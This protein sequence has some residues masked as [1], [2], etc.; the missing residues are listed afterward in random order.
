MSKGFSRESLDLSQEKWSD[1]EQY[2]ACLGR[3]LER[4]KKEIALAGPFINSKTAWKCGILGQVLLYRVTMLAIGC[5]DAWKS[6]NVV[7]SVLAARALLE[8]IAVC[9]FIKERLQSSSETKNVDEI[10]ELANAQLFSTRN[11]EIVSEGFGFQA[12][13]ILTYI[14]KLDKQVSGVR[15]SYDFLSEWCH[16]NG[17]GHLFTYGEINKQTG[18]VKFFEIAP[19]VKG[20]Q[21][22]VVTC[23]M[24]I[25]F[26]EG[27]MDTFDSMIELL[28]V[29]DNNGPWLSE[30]T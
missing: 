5:A 22:H 26:V 16:P 23:F 29:I 19:R 15:E 1:V 18:T 7:C 14:D 27:V 17:S 4:R 12:R 25:L 10:E 28:Y 6:G 9:K 24:M 30:T 8:T 11:E 3:L 13:N 2:N 20:I 21:G